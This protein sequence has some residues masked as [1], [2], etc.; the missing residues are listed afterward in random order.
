[1]EK[2]QQRGEMLCL[3]P[4]KETVLG[5]GLVVGSFWLC[6]SQPASDGPAQE[7]RAALGTLAPLRGLCSPLCWL[8]VGQ[9]ADLGVNISCYPMLCLSPRSGL[10][11]LGN[12]EK[13][14]ISNVTLVRGWL[15]T[16]SPSHA[17]LPSHK[18][19]GDHTHIKDD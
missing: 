10:C 3:R 11:Q 18:H 12:K 1:M 5:A 13:E 6:A 8:R 15:G 19:G 9:G 17:A 16:W 4:Q 2:L 14:E 7:R